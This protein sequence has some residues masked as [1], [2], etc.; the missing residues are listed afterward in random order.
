MSRLPSQD[1]VENVIERHKQL[2]LTSCFE[3]APEMWLKVKGVILAS[4]YPEQERVQNDGRGYEPYPDDG[5]K[6][7]GRRKVHFRKITYDY[8]DRADV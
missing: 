6:K 8:P 5:I 4:C 3:S 1:L 2:R 7:Y